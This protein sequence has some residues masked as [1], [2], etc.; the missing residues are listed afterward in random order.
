MSIRKHFQGL[1]GFILF[2]ALFAGLAQAQPAQAAFSIPTWDGEVSDANGTPFTQAGGHP[3]SATTVFRVSTHPNPYAFGAPAPDE[4]IK[5]IRGELPPGFVGDPGAVTE[6]EADD[7]FVP[8]L[9]TQAKCPLSSQVG[10]MRVD[11][12]LF[13]GVQESLVPVY[14]MVPV[15]PESPA[16]FGFKL[17]TT[18]VKARVTI[19]TGSD[20]G[21]NVEFP[22]LAQGIGTIGSKFTVWG[23]PADPSHDSERGPCLTSED[24][25][26]DKCPSGLERRPFLTLPA[27][28]TPEGVGFETKLAIDSWDNPGFFERASFFSHLPPYHP[29]PAAPGPQQGTTGCEKVPFAPT[30]TVQPRSSRADAPTGLD[31]ELRV[32]QRLDPN[33]IEAAQPKTVKVTLPEGMSV[34]PASADGLVGCSPAQIGLDQPGRDSCPAGSKLGTVEIETPLLDETVDGSVYMAQQG[35][36]KFNSLLALYVSAEGGGAR[37]KLAG[38]VALDPGTGR[39]T[40]TFDDNPQLPFET[41]TMELK[42]GDRA[43]LITPAQCGTYTTEAEINSW[44]RPGEVLSSKSS[45]TIDQGCGGGFAPEFDAGTTNPVGGSHSPFV[46]RLSRADGSQ[47]LSTL[48]ATMPPGLTGKLAGIPYCPDAA[49][50]AVSGAEGTGAA[51]L[52]NPSCPAAS[53]VG[54]VSVGA[55][56]GASPF[57]VNTGRAYL[58]GPY[59]GAPLSIAFVTPALAGPFDLGSVVVRA[60]L[61]VNPETT[62][63]TAVS[64]SLPTILHGIPLDLRDVRVN[65][66]RPEFTLNPTSCDPMAFSGTATST[67]GA[68]APLAERFQAAG[69]ERLQFKPRLGLQLSGA[70]GRAGHP[71]LRATLTMPKDGA[72]IG[73]AVVTMPKATF[74]EQAHIRTICT[75]VQYAAKACPQASVYGY[76]KA[77]SPLLDKPLE[78]PVYLRSSSNKLPDLVAS[79]DGQIHVDLVGRIDSVN[80]R[81]RNTFATVPDAP[82]SKFTLNMQG[83]KKSL[84]VNS[85]P[86]CGT[87]PRATVRFDGHNGKVLTANPLVTAKCRK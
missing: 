39:L 51:Q 41:L 5:T 40:A 86:L 2:T 52:G 42:G 23:V 18:A 78:G 58:A 64:D 12:G 62:Q 55:G 1:A 27:S 61:Q 10:V 74:L 35:A 48:T 20:Y 30:L 57:Y 7:L 21:V 76:A 33:G 13:G 71:R 79:L 73:K 66:D 68:S 59:K 3:A 24:G 83:G 56:A 38:R 17:L 75:R 53:Q 16:E 9:G 46:L 84:L 67:Q 25:G 77:W 50:A 37:V 4:N 14:N 29:D 70:T 22:N 49:L 43:P 69:C 11:H 63:I 72:N 87:K 31:V 34:N 65:L 36:N 81:I 19:R 32:P 80:G 60:A 85:V 8:G 28:C 47:R 54:S 15:D 45:F 82:V 26:E 6:C 44:A